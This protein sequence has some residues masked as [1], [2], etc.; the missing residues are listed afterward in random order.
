MN[1]DGWHIFTQW[2]LA[3][4]NKKMLSALFD[5]L[6]TPEEKESIALRCLIIKELLQQKKTQREIATDLNVSTAKITRGSNELKRMPAFLIEFLHE[7]I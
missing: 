4:K 1:P 7:K 2:C 5:L 6:L 3:S